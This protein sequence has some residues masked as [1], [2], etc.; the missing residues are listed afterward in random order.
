MDAGRTFR[1]AVVS[2]ACAAALTASSAAGGSAGVTTYVALGDS[3]SA[4]PLV[5]V[6]RTAAG[7]YRSSRNYPSLVARAL[8][9]ESLDDRTCSGA[10]TADLTQRQLPDIPPQFEA[11]TAD[12]D[13]VTV[14]IGG[15]DSS[16]YSILTSGCPSLRA[17]DPT[18]SPCRRAMHEYGADR[19][20]TAVATTEDRLVDVVAAVRERAPDA[21]IMLVGYPQIAPRQ[22]TCPDLLPLADG[23]Y[24]Y[25]N[26]VILRLTL[27]VRHAAARTNVDYI[28][29]WKASQGHDVCSED[30]WVNGRTTDP[31]RALAYHPF[32]EEQAA[33]AA[34]ILD[35]L[36]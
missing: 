17:S 24:R 6:T 1:V 20:F 10:D 25:A 9:G 21:R 4:A 11:L 8:T 13:L 33:V 35:E 34:L 18:G 23:D 7:C 3:Y 26:Q 19:L 14:G 2:L 12:T 27:A 30:S 29:V 31:K 15:N 32:A 28:D 16:V 5:P 36:G 22:G